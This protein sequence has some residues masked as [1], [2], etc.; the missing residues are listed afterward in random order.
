MWQSCPPSGDELV[1]SLRKQL[2][3][4]NE[5]YKKLRK[6]NNDLEDRLMD[7]SRN[8]ELI[9]SLKR[10][11]TYLGKLNIGAYFSLNQKTLV[12][13]IKQTVEECNDKISLVEAECNV[14]AE[15]IADMRSKLNLYAKKLK[16][17][18]Q[19]NRAL[20]ETLRN[21]NANSSFWQWVRWGGFL[22][23]EAALYSTEAT[24]VVYGATVPV[25]VAV[26]AAAVTGCVCGWAAY[27][28]YNYFFG[29]VKPGVTKITVK[30]KSDS[31]IKTN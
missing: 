15:I 9:R 11:R 30:T 8:K 26:N 12:R 21:Q 5:D 4:L 1:S 29:D 10:Q 24:V 22:A 18:V 25:F 6:I 19:K 27:K 17:R 2:G 16:M 7:D 14:Q 23:A 3:A 20:E 13:K 28:G 31:K